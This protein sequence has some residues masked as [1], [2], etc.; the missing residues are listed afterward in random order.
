MTAHRFH[1]VQCGRAVNGAI[2]FLWGMACGGVGES[3]AFRRL[4]HFM[5][6]ALLSCDEGDERG[7]LREHR[8]QQGVV[9]AMV[10]ETFRR[11]R[12]YACTARCTSI[13]CHAVLV[14]GG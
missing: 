7:R 10:G 4:A 5:C 12:A 13:A 2:E 9:L 6:A 1:N 11:A 3:G 14:A 8:F